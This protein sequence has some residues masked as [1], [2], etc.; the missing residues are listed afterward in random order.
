MTYILLQYGLTALHE[1]AWKGAVPVIQ[2]LIRL[3]ADVDA[4]NKVSGMC[5]MK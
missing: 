5:V 2:T 1:A 4:H 3:G